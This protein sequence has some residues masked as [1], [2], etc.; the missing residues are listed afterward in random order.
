MCCIGIH[1]PHTHTHTH[2]HRGAIQNHGVGAGGTRNISGTSYYHVALEKEL[3]DLH[4]KDAALVF[5]S[6]YVAN[7]AS[8]STLGKMMPNCVVF[9]DAGNHNSM[10]VG[11]RHGKTKKE[12]FRHNDPQHLEELL[13][14]Y[15]PNI[16]KLVA[17]ES[18]YSMSGSIAPIQEIC[19][20][21][22][23]YNALT[24]IDEVHA[25]GLYGEHGAGVGER[26]GLMDDL[27]IISGTLGKAFGVAGGYIA[28]SSKLIDMVRS[29]A[30]GFIFT[31]AMPPM[32]AVAARKSVQIL[33]SEEGQALRAKHQDSVRRVQSL[34]KEAGLPV[35]PSPSHI[36]PLHVSRVIQCVCVF[37]PLQVYRL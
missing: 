37:Y 33:K 2:T 14:K 9:S 3:A 16:P 5:S 21:A 34:L 29:Y 17:F 25:V 30:D 12:I 32:Q 13:R 22:H 26:D 11:I 24:F 15:D 6:C 19:D 36:I 27:D 31:T 35:V 4:K 18:V 20:I 28:G 1:I 7:D 23:K 10:I 8:L